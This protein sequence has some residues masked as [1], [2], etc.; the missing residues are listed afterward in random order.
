MLGHRW[1]RVQ[2]VW[3]NGPRHSPHRHCVHPKWH[4]LSANHYL[5]DQPPRT[6]RRYSHQVRL[7]GEELLL[8]PALIKLPP[9]AVKASRTAG[10]LQLEGGETV[11]DLSVTP[12]GCRRR[13]MCSCHI[14]RAIC[15]PGQHQVFHHQWHLKEPHLSREVGQIPPTTILCDWWQNFAAQGGR[16]TLSMCSGS[17]TNTTLPPLRRWSG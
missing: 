14:R 1:C 10:D 17:T 7:W 13:Q 15:P 4:R 16:R 8:T 3:P 2:A 6:D 11:A 12:G 9:L 5:A